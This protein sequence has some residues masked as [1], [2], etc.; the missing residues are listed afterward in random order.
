LRDEWVDLAAELAGAHRIITDNPEM[1][2]YLTDR[3]AYA[4][5]IKYDLYRQ[6][7]REDYRQQIDLARDRLEADALLVVF[8]KPS[9]DEAEAIGLLG[10]AAIDTY[11]GAVVSA[12]IKRRHRICGIGL[13]EYI[14]VW[15]NSR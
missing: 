7:F 15:P 9:D 13:G 4:M 3:P 14:R 1:V 12:T 10:V 2:Y 6:V 5:P 8:G 11:D